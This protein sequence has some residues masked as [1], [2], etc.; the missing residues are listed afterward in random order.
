MNRENIYEQ[1]NEQ[2]PELKRRSCTQR[3]MAATDELL[4]MLI[5]I[6]LEEELN[7]VLGVDNE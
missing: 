3:V 5:Q 1:L 7:N 6:Q 4:D 2:I